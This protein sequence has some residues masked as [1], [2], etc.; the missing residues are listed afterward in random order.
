MNAKFQ[1]AYDYFLK[2]ITQDEAVVGVL[3]F[4]SVQQGSEKDSSDLD[5]YIILNGEEGWNYKK[6]R[7]GILV[8]AY[9][10]P[11]KYWEKTIQ[12]SHQAMIAFATGTN[13]YDSNGYVEGLINKAKTVYNQ[14]PEELNPI[15]KANW[16][17]TLTELLS[18]LEGL[19][20]ETRNGAIHYGWSITRALEGYCTLNRIWP[21]KQ[22]KLVNN[23]SLQDKELESYL[24]KYEHVSTLDH[25]KMIIEYILN[26]H[27]GRIDEYEGPRMKF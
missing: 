2:E 9:F 5:F 20:N 22:E 21:M 18:D 11:A 10:Y 17:I 14:G 19:Q 24:E 8:E 1:E 25:A 6:Y 12:E 4:G 26:R 13:V 3:F 16:R 15:Q 27:G 23:L 7:K